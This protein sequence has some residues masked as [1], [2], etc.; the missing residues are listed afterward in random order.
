MKRLL[1]YRP[2][3][4]PYVFRWT[5]AIF[6]FALFAFVIEEYFDLFDHFR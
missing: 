1:A 2:E 3:W 5:A 4:R 6:I